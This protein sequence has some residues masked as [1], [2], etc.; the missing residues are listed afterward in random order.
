MMK[1]D[2]AFATKVW[3]G[4]VQLF[5]TDLRKVVAEEGGG[6]AYWASSPSDDLA[7]AANTPAS[8]DM[9]YWEVWGNPAHPPSK[10]LE[11][12]PRFMSEYGLQAW[13]VQRTIDAFAK[14]GEQRIATPV[15]EAHQKFWPVKAMNGS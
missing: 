1:A 4:Y 10:Y 6:V 11:I 8:G 15:I 12:T 2:P 13:P 9:H 3:S 7:E 14:R 5:G